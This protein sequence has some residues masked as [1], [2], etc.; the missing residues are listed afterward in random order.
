MPNDQI[1]AFKIYEGLIRKLKERN[2]LVAKV[3]E[4]AHGYRF[5]SGILYLRYPELLTSISA[6]FLMDS[7]H[8][9]IL[10]QAATEMDIQVKLE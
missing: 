1:A 6:R 3:V 9:P 5:E 10:D 4:S 8:K 2:E 7:Q